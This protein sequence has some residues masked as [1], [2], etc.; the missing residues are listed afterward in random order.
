MDYQRNQRQNNGGNRPNNS[1][2]LGNRNMNQSTNAASGAAP[3]MGN[4][5]MQAEILFLKQEAAYS[6]NAIFS[7]EVDFVS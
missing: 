4:M 1:S 6:R 7:L 2:N 5:N 3:L